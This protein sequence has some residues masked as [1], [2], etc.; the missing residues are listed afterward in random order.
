[1]KG[2][3]WKRE[4][5]VEVL[6]PLLSLGY[7]VTR[8]CRI[9]GIPHNTV[10]G[11]LA[12]DE[13]LRLKIEAWQNLPNTLARRNLVKKIEEGDSDIS[14]F[15]L[16]RRGKD[17]FSLRREV[18]ESEDRPI[19]IIDAGKNPYLGEAKKFLPEPNKN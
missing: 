19:I 14:R 4:K 13:E 1:M 8:A 6:R 18:T 7:T 2:K 3:A 15:W 16:E 5:V 9:A 10:S 17:D 11:W 12:D